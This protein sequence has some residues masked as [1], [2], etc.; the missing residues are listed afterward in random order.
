MTLNHLENNGIAYD[1]YPNPSTSENVNL[2]VIARDPG[3]VKITVTDALGKEVYRSQQS[4]EILSEGIR[5]KFNQD[6]RPGMYF[7]ILEQNSSIRKLK[8]I[9]K[10]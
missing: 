10:N 3:D 4:D 6:L 1:L 9:I 2:R 8:F 5:M 7:M